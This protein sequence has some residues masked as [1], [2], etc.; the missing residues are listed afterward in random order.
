MNKTHLSLRDKHSD[1]VVLAG[2]NSEICD[3]FH[4][5]LIPYL[6]QV[7]T[8]VYL[9]FVCDHTTTKSFVKRVLQVPAGL[10]FL[11]EFADR[12]SLRR[13][14]RCLLF[15]DSPDLQVL[16]G[17]AS[18][19]FRWSLP[20]DHICSERREADLEDILGRESGDGITVVWIDDDDTVSGE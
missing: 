12:L 7:M 11:H 2:R 19:I 6:S 3:P 18:F 16:D 9:H 1:G 13:I 17:I 20:G 5:Q 14:H 10:R 4:S 8:L 15:Y